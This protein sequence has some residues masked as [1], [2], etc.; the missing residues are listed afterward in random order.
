MPKFSPNQLARAKEL[1]T[2]GIPF[3]GEILEKFE[4]T[5]RALYLAQDPNPP[6]TYVFD[7]RS[8][9][10]GIIIDF[11]VLNDSDQKIRLAGARLDFPWSAQFHWLEDPFRSN[12]RGWAYVFPAPDP[13]K[14]DRGTVLNHHF[15]AKI[16]LP[17]EDLRGFL[18]GKEEARIPARYENYQRLQGQLLVFD[19]K[20]IQRTLALDFQVCREKKVHEQQKIAE[21]LLKPTTIL[22]K[23]CLISAKT[24]VY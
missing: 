22:K 9:G 2:L 4:A 5:S 16:L 1:Q 6:N 7:L 14:Y 23:R 15:G 24:P 12:P 3:D 8:G 19:G 18:L 13:Q 21:G 11:I 10:T 17:G 20:G